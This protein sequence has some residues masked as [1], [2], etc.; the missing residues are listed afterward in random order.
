M[1]PLST[2][3]SAQADELRALAHQAMA[4]DP[5]LGRALV[6]HATRLGLASIPATEMERE[7]RLARR[8]LDEIVADAAEE[9][10]AIARRHASARTIAAILAPVMPPQHRGTCQ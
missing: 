1:T 5:T 4:L 3:L 10:R 9:E 7:L 8:T 2:R 6:Y